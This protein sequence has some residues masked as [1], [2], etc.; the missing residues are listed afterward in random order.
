MD[1]LNMTEQSNRTSMAA[2]LDLFDTV[3]GLWVPGLL[4]LF[5][6]VGN[7]L[8]LWVLSRDRSKSATMT[9]LKALAASDFILLAGALGQQVVPLTCDWTHSTG[10][11]CARQGYLQVYAW[12]IVCTAQTATIWLTVLIS[13]ERYVAICAPLSAG[14]VGVGKVLLAIVVI[15]IV[16]IVFNLPRF[17]EYR[18][19]SVGGVDGVAVRVEL[20]DTE[21]RLDSV[22]RY[23]YNTALFGIVMYAAPLSTVAALNIRLTS[24][25]TEARRNWSALN[26][27]QKRELRAT[28]LPLVIVLVF[29]VC[30]TVSLLGFVLDAVYAAAVDKYP[31]WLQQFSAVANVLVIFNSAI[32]FVLML[33]FG[34]KFR[35]MLRQALSDCC[36]C[37]SCRCRHDNASVVPG[38]GKASKHRNP[39]STHL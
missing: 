15:G 21:L 37:C 1:K 7:A 6:I 19:V 36:C 5:G 18:P 32:N 11:F 9:S 16:S 30:C 3:I 31:R 34:A 12:P 24:A 13:T 27:T 10:E 28:V 25:V 23:L 4:A 35:R 8:S 2:E 22:Y 39:R 33:C 14:R 17:F 38:L 26:S 29:A 20:R